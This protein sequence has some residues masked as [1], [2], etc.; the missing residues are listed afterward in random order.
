MGH[1]GCTA[2]AAEGEEATLAVAAQDTT[3]APRGFG[4]KVLGVLVGEHRH[5]GGMHAI[6]ITAET[7]PLHRAY[8][9]T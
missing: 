2:R 9:S 4:A 7:P 8:G 6:E 1:A 5:E 3:A